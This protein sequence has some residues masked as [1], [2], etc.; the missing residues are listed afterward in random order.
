MQKRVL[1]IIN[2][3]IE[4][5]GRKA[6]KN[7]ISTLI[8]GAVFMFSGFAV[9][10]TP[11]NTGSWTQVGNM[12][13][14]GGMFN[15]NCN[16]ASSGCTYDDGNDFWMAFPEIYTGQEILFVTGDRQIW[17]VA[18]YSD[19]ANIIDAAAGVFAPNITW[20]DAGLNGSSIGSTVG[21]ILHRNGAGEDPWITLRGSH[22][23]HLTS[24]AFGVEN[25]CNLMIWGESGYLGGG[26]HSTLKNASGGVEV[27]ISRSASV[28]EPSILALVVLGLTGIGFVRRKARV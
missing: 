19:V 4:M 9:E 10:A 26:I 2:E 21:N 23:A 25:D 28:P 20:S 14:G 11:L 8:M 7:K 15:G 18:E 24:D 3:A 13:A 6:R 17:G 27:Y 12:S 16:L 5:I 1:H 22:C